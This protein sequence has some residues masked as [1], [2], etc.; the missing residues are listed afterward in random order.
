MDDRVRPIART[1]AL[2][3]ILLCGGRGTRLTGSTEPETHDVVV[4]HAEK[5]LVSVDGRPMVDRVL[6]V[7]FSTDSIES[8]HAVASP[9]TPETLDHLERVSSTSLSSSASPTA[10][11]PDSTADL[12]VH[13]G[14]GE[15]YVADLTSTIEAVGTPA[16][17]V[18]ADLPL[19]RESHVD[20]TVDRFLHPDGNVDASGDGPP[21]QR[22]LSVCVPVETKRRLGVSADTTLQSGGRSLAPT[23]LNVVGSRTNADDGPDDADAE[24]SDPG[25][26]WV[27][28]DPDLAVNVNRPGD[29]A[30][31]R[32]RV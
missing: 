27:L 30:V 24:E 22:S 7:L 31:A 1:F 10:F 8:V 26:R 2:P 23:G 19:L 15:G 18:V 9:Q 13:E 14:T 6:E 32:D 20:S 21:S 4:D 17:T 11:V 28:D 25:R 5:P 29:L 3:A 16:L 12:H